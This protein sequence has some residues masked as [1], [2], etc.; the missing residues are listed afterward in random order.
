MYIHVFVCVCVCVYGA[1]KRVCTCL[2]RPEVDIT[3]P[4]ERLFHFIYEVRISHPNPELSDSAALV[5]MVV[6]SEDNGAS[7]RHVVKYGRGMFLVILE[8]LSS[9]KAKFIEFF[10]RQHMSVAQAVIFKIKHS[11]HTHMQRNDS[12]KVLKVS[13][14]HN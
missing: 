14:S 2:G 11:T 5:F 13:V 1:C 12:R 6:Y 9:S 8:I 3:N 10:L 7:Y 4:P